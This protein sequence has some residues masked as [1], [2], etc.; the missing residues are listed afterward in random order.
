MY[1]YISKTQFRG[2]AQVHGAL[3]ISW[4]ILQRLI[5]KGV[6]DVTNLDWKF[7]GIIGLLL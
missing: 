2:R 6:C 5:R 1:S 7:Q 3:P 4:P